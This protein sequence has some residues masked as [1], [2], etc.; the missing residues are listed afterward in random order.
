MRSHPERS[1]DI[2]NVRKDLCLSPGARFCTTITTGREIR[3]KYYPKLAI[4]IYTG[5]FHLLR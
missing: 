1:R 4:E 5:M 3:G 2:Y